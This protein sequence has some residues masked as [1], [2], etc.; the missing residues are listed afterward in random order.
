MKKCF[1]TA[2]FILIAV[3][4]SAM[5]PEQ[6]FKTIDK[7]KDGKASVEE[8]VEKSKADAQRKGWNFNEAQCVKKFKANDV[9]QDGF[10]TM[11]EFLKSRK[12]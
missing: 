12:K 8:W 5:T 9:D 11:D 3:V 6:W 10:L 7:N 4:A 2:G 1:I